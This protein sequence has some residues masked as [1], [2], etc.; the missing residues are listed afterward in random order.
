[1]LC[2]YLKNSVIYKEITDL[3]FSIE[4]LKK[5]SVKLINLLIR[6]ELMLLVAL[7]PITLGILAFPI[8]GEV[9]IL[10]LNIQFIGL[11]VLCGCVGIILPNILIVSTRFA[12]LQR[13]LEFIKFGLSGGGILETITEEDEEDE[14]E[15]FIS[16]LE[17]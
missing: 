9:V 6:V 15:S 11:I 10:I 3:K 14:E 5:L 8:L 12:R 13:M 1:M 17:I 7:V 16:S 2:I 4:K